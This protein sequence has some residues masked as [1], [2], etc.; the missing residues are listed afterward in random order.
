MR[1]SPISSQYP[2]PNPQSEIRNLFN[3]NLILNDHP[4]LLPAFQDPAD[5]VVVSDLKENE[6][7]FEFGGLEKQSQTK[8]GPAFKKICA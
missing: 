7:F 1:L 4:H 8:P 2:I 6:F 3:L 5:L